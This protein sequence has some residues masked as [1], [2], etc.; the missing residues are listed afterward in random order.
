MVGGEFALEVLT[1]GEVEDGAGG[2]DI[3]LD[4]HDAPGAVKHA[5][6]E[7]ALRT[8]HLIVI[9]LHGVNGA[10]AKFIVLR[11]RTKDRGK[12]DAGMRT[13]RMECH[14][15]KKRRKTGSKATL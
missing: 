13:L 4:H 12:E 11:I 6:R 9:K 15:K 10:A 7:S 14:G 1:A 2:G 5:K 3:F 8:G